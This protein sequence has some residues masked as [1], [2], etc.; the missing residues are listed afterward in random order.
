MWLEYSRNM[1]KWWQN[2]GNMV[3]GIGQDGGKMVAGIG[4]ECSAMVRRGDGV[5]IKLKKV[6]KFLCAQ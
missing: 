6:G 5:T 1:A 2:G 3:A 4:C